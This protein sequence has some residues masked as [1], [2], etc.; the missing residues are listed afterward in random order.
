MLKN[1]CGIVHF[2]T[3]FVIFWK[4]YCILFTVNWTKYF[5]GILTF[6]VQS[7]NFWLRSVQFS[8]MNWITELNAVHFLF[9]STSLDLS[10]VQCVLEVHRAFWKGKGR[11]FV[12]QGETYGAAK[13]VGKIISE[14]GVSV[15][16]FR[17]HMM[18]GTM[19]AN[20]LS[21][22]SVQY[23]VHRL[24]QN[25]DKV[26]GVAG[27][28]VQFLSGDKIPFSRGDRGWKSKSNGDAEAEAEAEA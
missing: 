18:G 16:S 19:Q 3:C 27:C 17:V 28:P 4:K 5:F 21:V 8:S 7:S 11:K 23:F 15:H 10:S 24:G 12:R 2:L 20:Y 25:R 22:S 9:S 13:P 26:H 6:I 1:H 14:I